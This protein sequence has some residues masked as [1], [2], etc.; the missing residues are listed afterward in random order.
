MKPSLAASLAEALVDEHVVAGE[1]PQDLLRHR[2]PPR[3]EHRPRREPHRLLVLLAHRVLGHGRLQLRHSLR[4]RGQ[5][6][7]AE[8]LRAHRAVRP[9]D[10]EV[11]RRSAELLAFCINN[12][13][14]RLQFSSFCLF[15][16]G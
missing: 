8:V 1:E 6:L 12:G 10:E 3:Q 4:R 13:R 2:V 7:D 14:N 11:K 5:T 16:F 15:G 9:G